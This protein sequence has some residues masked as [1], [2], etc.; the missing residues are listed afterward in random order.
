MKQPTFRDVELISA[1]LDGQLSQSDSVRLEI[2]LKTDAQLRMVFEELGQARSVLRKLPA[3]RAPRNFTLT[4]KMAGIKPPLPR[5]FP[6]FRFASILASVLFLFAYIANLSV[7]AITFLRAAAPVPIMGGRGGGGGNDSQAAPEA[8][9]A[10]VQAMPM[11]TA[12]PSVGDVASTPTAELRAFAPAPA[13]ENLAATEMPTSDAGPL[14][15]TN[16]DAESQAQAL[17][18]QEPAQL[19]VSA[20]L[21]FG[22]LCFAVVSGGSAYLL[23]LR[24]D[25]QWFNERSV[26]L[27]KMSARQITGFVLGI[28][29]LI[30][31]AFSIYWLSSTTFYVPVSA[32][33]LLPGG[34]GDKGPVIGGD[35]GGAA[36]SGAQSFTLLPGLGYSFSAVDASGL[37]TAIDFPQDVFKSEMVISYVPGVTILTTGVAYP[38]FTSFSLSPA[39]NGAQAQAPFTINL[40]YSPDITT[41]LDQNKLVLYWWSGTEW[42]DAA[43]TCNPASVYEHRLDVYRLIVTVCKMGS[44]V[45]VAP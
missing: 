41:G 30:A 11:P 20:F 4:A 33:P 3:R 45:L 35:K 34:L 44:F 15:K 38:T 43:A 40:D 26:H 29:V 22:L 17:P 28:L 27:E 18:T 6:I 21:L 1:Y 14:A 39:E 13:T 10:A 31:L 23:R 7:P 16:P 8:A 12:A 19:P 2:R 9:P 24:N 42:Q 25:R 5:T 36:P 37:V 32:A